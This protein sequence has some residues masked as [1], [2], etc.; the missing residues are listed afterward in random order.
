MTV[1]RATNARGCTPPSRGSS[2]RTSPAG[3]ARSGSPAPRRTS[4]PGAD[5]GPEPMSHPGEELVLLLDG[6]MTF[7]IDGEPYDPGDRRFDPLPH[8]APALVGEPRRPPGAR[9]L[10]GDPRLVSGEGARGG[11]SS[12]SAGTRSSPSDERGTWAEQRANAARSRA[13]RLGCGRPATSVLVTHGNGP[14]VG[15]LPC[16][17]CGCRPRSRRCR[18]TRSCAM[19]QGQLGYL[20]Q[21]A[22]EEARPGA[23]HGHG[24]HAG[25]RRRRAT[26]RSRTRPSRSA[27]STTSRAP[28]PRPTSAA[29]RWPRTP[30]A[31]GGRVS[32]ARRRT[33][34][35]SS[36][37]IRRSL[38]RGVL[39]IAAGG[40]G[41][42][43]CAG[44]AAR[45]RR[46]R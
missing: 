41:I 19:T 43:V 20:L 42:P 2:C 6:R 34:S 35:S 10:A 11:S 38:E 26:R 7:T 25:R 12:P 23:S 24:A 44:R 37:T 9:R 15:A 39:V 32:R 5:S 30:D 46:R 13:R 14:Q 29:G 21:T 40:G 16:S 17:T 18:S 31:A 36:S 4:S 3:T 22:I 1:I 8:R 45:G 28:Q 33:R 27:G